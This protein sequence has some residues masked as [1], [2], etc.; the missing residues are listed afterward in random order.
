MTKRQPKGTPAGKGGQ[1]APDMSG[2]KPPVSPD[3]LRS[4]ASALPLNTDGTREEFDASVEATRAAFELVLQ[5]KVRKFNEKN[6]EIPVEEPTDPKVTQAW[7]NLIEETFPDEV[8]FDPKWTPSDGPPEPLENGKKYPTSVLGGWNY[9]NAT[10]GEHKRALTEKVVDAL[11]PHT[12]HP[13]DVELRQ[14]KNAEPTFLVICMQCDE[15]IYS[16]TGT[17]SDCGIVEEAVTYWDAPTPEEAEQRAIRAALNSGPAR[18]PEGWG[19]LPAPNDTEYESW[20]ANGPT[21]DLVTAMNGSNWDDST[22][23]ET[24]TAAPIPMSTGMVRA[25][26]I[27]RIDA[28]HVSYYGEQWTPQNSSTG[29]ELQMVVL[30]ELRDG[31]W[32]AVTAYNDYTGWGCQD[33][34][35][36]SVANTRK[37]A[38]KYGLTKEDRILLGFEQAPLETW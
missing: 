28:Y 2:K 19:P 5:G 33:G 36:K 3:D 6:P 10:F 8:F 30:A 17:V 22:P 11:R 16:H 21:G 4:L 38:I 29:T 1:F 24:F 15:E 20:R 35:H 37:D 27:A 31:R 13:L 12:G 9:R 26:D 14:D 23:Y 25:Q 34:S 32:L 18:M 7:E